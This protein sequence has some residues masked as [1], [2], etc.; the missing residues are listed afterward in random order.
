MSLSSLTI[1]LDEIVA[2]KSTS[3]EKRIQLKERKY[4]KSNSTLSENLSIKVRFNTL[5]YLLKIID[6]RS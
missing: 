6:K 4:I 2:Y 3:D 5:I 1:V